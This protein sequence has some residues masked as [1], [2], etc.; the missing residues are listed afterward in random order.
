[1]KNIYV[2]NTGKFHTFFEV[3]SVAIF[4]KEENFIAGNACYNEIKLLIFPLQF[5]CVI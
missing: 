3:K 2:C 1:M 5:R 4:Y